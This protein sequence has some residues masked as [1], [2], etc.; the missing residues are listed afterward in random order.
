MLVLL[1]ASHAKSGS[2]WLVE[3]IAT[4]TLVIYVIRT[5]WVPFFNSKPE[6][7]RQAD[8]GTLI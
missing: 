4:Q 5:R 6:A 3:S 1:H 7:A 2:S 8:R